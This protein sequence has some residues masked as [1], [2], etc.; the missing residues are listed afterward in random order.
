MVVYEKIFGSTNN[1]NISKIVL[2]NCIFTLWG[3]ELCWNCPVD[4]LMPVIFRNFYQCMLL[5]EN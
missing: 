1:Q 4:S 5:L 3:A 2:Y